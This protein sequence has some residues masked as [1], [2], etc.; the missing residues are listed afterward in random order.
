MRRAGNQAEDGAGSVGD[1][2]GTWALL[3]AAF[4]ALLLLLSIRC[5]QGPQ[6]ARAYPSR[7]LPPEPQPLL[8]APPPMDDEYFPCSD[9]HEDEP[10]D[11][12]VRKLEDEHDE[13]A[14]AHG[15]TWCLDCHDADH[16]DELHLADDR[17]VE[18]DE[19]WRLCTQCHGVK[20]ADW[21]AGV[22]G[23]RTGN[24]WGPK[25]YWSCVACHDP[26][27]PRYQALEPMRPPTRPEQIRLAA[28][29]GQETAHEAP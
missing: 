24:W 22:H 25:E 17:R 8:R 1:R 23:K 14:L 13:L 4:V 29:S 7:A 2:S 21:R 10:T 28:P 3:G 27:S 15:E 9:C 16:R 20:L 11:R 26:H 6:S 12:T 18:F 5:A 19:S